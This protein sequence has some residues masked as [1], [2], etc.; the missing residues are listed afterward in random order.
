VLD[1]SS[2]KLT[3]LRPLGRRNYENVRWWRPP[4]P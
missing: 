2:G 3:V 4:P 1:V